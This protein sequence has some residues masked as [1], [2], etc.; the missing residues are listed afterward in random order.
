MR[1]IE[2]VLPITSM[3][4]VPQ[5]KTQGDSGV[6]VNQLHFLET[7]LG[8][9]MEHILMLLLKSMAGTKGK[10]LAVSLRCQAQGLFGNMS[11]QSKDYDMLVLAPP[12]QTELY[13]LQLR[14]RRQIASE[15]LLALGQDIHI[16][17]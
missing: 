4:N 7:G 16:Y 14:E 17:L 2:N 15:T 8:R 12:N 9:T 13:R 1:D 6:K 5:T 3:L 10:S 11:T